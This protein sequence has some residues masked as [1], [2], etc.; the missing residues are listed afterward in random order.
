MC[1]DLGSCRESLVLEYV[2]L[3]HCVIEQGCFLVDCVEKLASV[4]GIQHMFR[5]LCGYNLRVWHVILRLVRSGRMDLDRLK[6]K[7]RW[8][9]LP[10]YV[11][12]PVMCNDIEI[13]YEV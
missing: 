9:L 4:E 12:R 10:G 3:C 1:T 13:M 8:S 7:G 2:E 6:V 5:F 11:L